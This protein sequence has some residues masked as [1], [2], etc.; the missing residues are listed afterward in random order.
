MSRNKL[1]ADHLLRSC[2]FA[3]FTYV[4]GEY[5]TGYEVMEIKLKTI[6]TMIAEQRSPSVGSDS[7]TTQLSVSSTVESNSDAKTILSYPSV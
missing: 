5:F 6:P 1:S 4:A 3:M 7:G 2:G